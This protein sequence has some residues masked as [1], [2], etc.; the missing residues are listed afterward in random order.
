MVMLPQ[1]EFDRLSSLANDA[2]TWAD[3]RAEAW[4]RNAELRERAA[5]RYADGFRDGYAAHDGRAERYRALGI[6]FEEWASGNV[7]GTPPRDAISWV[8][9]FRSRFAAL[10]QPEGPAWVP[11]SPVY[12]LPNRFIPPAE[13]EGGK[14][15]V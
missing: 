15:E 3:D 5:E 8:D 11:A 6:E 2:E 7:G 9:Y 10:A 13:P 4:T 12:T 1:E 14:E